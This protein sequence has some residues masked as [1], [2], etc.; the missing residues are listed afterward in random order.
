MEITE[1]GFI[2]DVSVETLSLTT[3]GNWDMGSPINLEKAMQASDRFGGHI[4]SG[5][6]DG[7]G[8]VISLLRRC[9]IMAFRM[10]AGGISAILPTRAQLQWMGLVLL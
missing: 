5:H 8:E 1:Q 10:R 4:V 9:Q 3:V 7:I 6:V 2:A